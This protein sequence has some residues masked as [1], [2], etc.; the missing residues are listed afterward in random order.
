MHK[1]INKNISLTGSFLDTIL[2]QKDY[3]EGYHAYMPAT[4]DLTT[5]T[6]HESNNGKYAVFVTDSFG[7]VVA[8][9]LSQTFQRTD[10]VDL[11]YFSDNLEE[12]IQTNK[13]DVVIYMVNWTDAV[14][15]QDVI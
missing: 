13:P 6:N 4:Y 7:G 5:L 3:Q 9:F 15:H 12:Y 11:R 2:Y 10:C 8:P 1:L 14:L